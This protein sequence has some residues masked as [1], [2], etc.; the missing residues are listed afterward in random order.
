MIGYGSK[1]SEDDSRKDFEKVSCRYYV[2][3]RSEFLR[4]ANV[5]DTIMTVPWDKGC[6]YQGRTISWVQ[7]TMCP[8]SMK[9]ARTYEKLLVPEISDDSN[10][11]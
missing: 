4:T 6:R 8:G 5:I 11:K 9:L 3:N 7:R 2:Q 1:W 10:E